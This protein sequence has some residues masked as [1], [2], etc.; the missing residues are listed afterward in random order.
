MAGGAS[1]GASKNAA[2]LYFIKAFIGPGCLSLPLAFQNAGLELG[3]V[4]LFTL[5]VAVTLNLRTL[6]LCKRFYA[7]NTPPPTPGGRVHKTTT[8]ADVAERALG[9]YG[10]KVI[11]VLIHIVQLGVCA[12]YF[13]FFGEN[14]RALLP[15]K[16][17]ERIG[18]RL[19]ALCV[20]PVY[21][22]LALLKSVKGLAK[23]AALANALIFLAIGI[24]LFSAA[25]AMRQD[26]ST[27][28]QYAVAKPK[29]LPLFFGT[30]VYSFEGV[31]NMLPVENALRNSNDVWTI[32]YGGMVIVV[33][34]YATV[35][36]CG[37]AAW[38]DVTSGSI[39]AEIASHD[40]ASSLEAA[41]PVAANVCTI[42]A[43]I[44]T[45]PIQ[46]FPS[47]ELLEASFFFKERKRR[48][49]QLV[50]TEDGVELRR[51]S[52]LKKHSDIHSDDIGNP[53]HVE[54]DECPGELDD[55]V[56]TSPL[57]KRPSVT[58]LLDTPE[59]PLPDTPT[60]AVP[61]TAPDAKAPYED[62]PDEAKEA[63]FNALVDVELAKRHEP[64]NE[65]DWAVPESPPPR[66]VPDAAAKRK[67]MTWPR[68]FFRL[69]VVFL[70][71]L[72]A[73]AVPDLG[74]LIALLGALT[75]SI[76]SLIA[77]ALINRRCP[78][79]KGAWE[80]VADGATVVIGVVGGTLGTYQAFLNVIGGGD[81]D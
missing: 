64:A 71:F 38:P 57:A 14:M 43:V 70:T 67:V 11:E 51:P 26:A 6:V 46:L 5:A 49:R 48:R 8:Y 31:C 28:R 65:P 72:A 4:T 81:L 61:L 10:R 39:T 44:F 7:D 32:L 40:H 53:M 27:S 33:A 75:G 23:F 55:E 25:A 62:A 17:R 21:G 13:D 36:A 37:Y 16:E 29:T 68:V 9:K 15:H 66:P 60:S 74:A 47:M 12:V 73:I 77:P 58:P 3:L 56:K 54:D 76:L 1:S 34:A 45:F 42:V 63:A 19:L 69:G 18:V 41:G 79:P 50:S 22:S 20:F 78:R 52:F 35:G 24:V 59:A 30:V 2:L 80:C